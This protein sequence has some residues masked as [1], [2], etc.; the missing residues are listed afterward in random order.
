MSWTRHRVRRRAAAGLIARHG[1]DSVGVLG[2]AR[3][4]NEEN[5]RRAE[6]RARRHRHEQRRL[7]RAR[8]PRAERRG[9]EADARRRRGDQLVRRHRARAHD[10]GRRRQPTESHPVVGA[11]IKQAA[12]RGAQAHRHRSARIELAQ[13][14][15]C[16]LAA[17]AGHERRRC[18]TRWRTHLRRGPAATARSSRRRVAA[19]PE[20]ES[21]VAA[22]TPER[23]AAIC[24]V[25]P[26]AIRRAAR[27][28]AAGAPAMSVHGLGMT[29]HVQGTEGVMALINLALLTGNIGQARRR[30]QPAAR[31]EQRAG[32]G[33]HGLRAGAAARLR[34]ARRRAATR[35]RRCGASR[36]RSPAGSTCWR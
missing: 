9:A 13:D 23:A 17:P 2:S 24:G 16:H 31:A 36:C 10:P 1:P 32:R 30:H 15:D 7:L 5:Y 35:S 12:R 29:E 6:V 18:S 4:T 28:Y 19:L 34:A 14:A 25:E 33:A 8:L 21:F 11:R 26:E 3:A 27:L 22:W 20:F